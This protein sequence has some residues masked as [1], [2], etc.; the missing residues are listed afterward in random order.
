MKWSEGG[1]EGRGNVPLRLSVP[2]PLAHSPGGLLQLPPPLTCV[3][4]PTP[5]QHCS[6]GSGQ[7]SAQP[8]Q[9]SAAQQA[10]CRPRRGGTDRTG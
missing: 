2:S 5:P 1:Q 4:D 7:L 6:P 8:A 9:R 10:P 3:P